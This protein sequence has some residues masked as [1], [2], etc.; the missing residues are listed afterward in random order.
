MIV[1]LSH[2]VAAICPY[3]ATAVRV[4]ELSVERQ[5]GR[6]AVNNNVAAVPVFGLSWPGGHNISI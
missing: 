6:E 1:E 5:F 3:G 4:R 2:E